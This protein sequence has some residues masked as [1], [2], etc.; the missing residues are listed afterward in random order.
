MVVSISHVSV[1][2][3]QYKF[4]MVTFD[5]RAR[6]KV[7]LRAKD[8][9]EIYRGFP[10]VVGGGGG[11]NNLR[12]ALYV[13]RTRAL[14]VDAG[15]RPLA[16]R[17]VVVLWDGRSPDAEFGTLADEA[18]RLK[19]T[20]GADVY[21]I[22]SERHE[23]TSRPLVEAIA[24]RPY[25]THT[26]SNSTHHVERAAA[27]TLL[28]IQ[29][30]CER[31]LRATTPAAAALRAHPTTTAAVSSSSASTPPSAR[32]ESLQRSCVYFFTGCT[33]SMRQ[34]LAKFGRVVFEI[35]E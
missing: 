8:K 14:S 19:T 12:E 27:N 7:E 16:Y 33:G 26:R 11:K 25:A 13:A 18:P 29:L 21:V 6:L 3:T 2:E 34:K 31:S 15:M 20:S 22:V 1:S 4:A 5:D 32:S 9:D 24:S 28:E 23:A 35:C 17:A 10:L 30:N